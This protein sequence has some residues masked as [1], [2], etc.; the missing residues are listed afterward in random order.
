MSPAGT[1]PHPPGD[2]PTSCPFLL[3]WPFPKPPHPVPQPVPL[4][5]PSDCIPSLATYLLHLAGH[6]GFL[7]RPFHS[8]PMGLPASTTLLPSAA[9]PFQGPSQQPLPGALCLHRTKCKLLPVGSQSR[10]GVAVSPAS[11][12]TP[13]AHAL[14]GALALLF[15][16]PEHCSLRLCTTQFFCCSG[17]TFGIL[18]YLLFWLCGS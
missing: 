15:P 7:P 4:A 10:H 12:H 14:L 18:V 3:E 1:S 2:G 5:R 9:G 8:L 16:L 17:L 13:P 6:Q 11:N